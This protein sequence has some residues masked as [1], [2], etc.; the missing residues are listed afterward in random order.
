L[1]IITFSEVYAHTHNEYYNALA[2][3]RAN[4]YVVKAC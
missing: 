2:Y 3:L 1:L 4:K